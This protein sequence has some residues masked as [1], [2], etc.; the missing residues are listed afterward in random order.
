MQALT[1][2]QRLDLIVEK[3]RRPNPEYRFRHGLVQEVAYAS[4]VD[5]KRRKLHKRVGEALEDIY[6]ESPE[7]TYGLA[8]HF[9]EADEPEKA[10][11][12]LL[13][14]GDAA[15]AVYADREALEHYRH[16]RAFMACT[17]DE[18]RARDT[19][20]KMALA[21]HLA[22]RLREGRGDVRRGFRLPRPRGPAAADHR[23]P[24]DGFGRTEATFS[25]RRVLD[26]GR[27]LRG[28]SSAAC[29]WSTRS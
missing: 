9:T 8:R 19:L 13:K 18:R 23:A 2:L 25:R 14:A 27:L 29:S 24:R 3:R 12:Y 20:F 7:E 4:L 6:Q 26:R 5:S 11:E 21:Y 16:A 17:G 15:R 28:C 22:V 1:E 10:V